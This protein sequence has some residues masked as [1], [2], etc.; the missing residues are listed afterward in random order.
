MILQL[1]TILGALLSNPL[2]PDSD[3]QDGLGSTV[4]TVWQIFLKRPEI[5]KYKYK[6][7]LSV[8]QNDYMLAV[9]QAEADPTSALRV[10][11]TL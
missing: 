2:N 4:A 11:W 8:V 10:Y 6:Y 7:D 9:S 3:D 1:A 5:Y